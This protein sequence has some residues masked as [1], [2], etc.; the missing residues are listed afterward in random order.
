MTI[1]TDFSVDSSGNIRYTGSG[2]N[3]TVIAFHRWLQDLADDAVAAGDDLIDITDATP[4]ERSTDN[5]ITL[6]SPYN[7]DDVAAE[8]LYDGSI[9]QTGGDVVYSGLVVVGAVESGTQLQIV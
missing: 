1:A 8:H 6:N 9:T 7:I 3:Y 2:A 5:I 4:S